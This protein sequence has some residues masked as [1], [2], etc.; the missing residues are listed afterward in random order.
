MSTLATFAN[1]H[2][3]QIFGLSTVLGVTCHI[4]TLHLEPDYILPQLFSL[5]ALVFAVLTYVLSLPTGSLL[6]G[7]RK[8][9][10]AA[11]GFNTALTASILVHRLL[12]HR[13]RGFKGP[14]PA[15]VT[16]LYHLKR[17]WKKCQGHLE[18]QR[19]H[20]KYGDFVRIGRQ[21]RLRSLQVSPA[22]TRCYRPPRA[23]HH[24][25]RCNT[26]NLRLLLAVHSR[27]ILRTQRPEGA[28]SA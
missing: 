8:S 6:D 15:K 4:S 13:L 12:L 9:G 17:I 14:I 5:Y 27:Y 25:S 18:M 26:R 20:E 24:R 21:S 28:Y 2:Q 22:D 10:V 16:K 23:L 11:V 1:A 19:L 7:L 3:A